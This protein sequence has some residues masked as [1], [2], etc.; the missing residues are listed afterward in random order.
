MGQGEPR[1]LL[2]HLHFFCLLTEFFIPTFYKKSVFSL[3]ENLE[4]FMF[5]LIRPGPMNPFTFNEQTGK[6]I[7]DKENWWYGFIFMI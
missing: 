1:I 7:K 6:K 3:E 5:G 2:L 4:F